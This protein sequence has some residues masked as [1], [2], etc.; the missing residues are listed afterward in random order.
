MTLFNRVMG[1]FIR[2]ITFYL[3]FLS[4]ELILDFGFNLIALL[5]D[6]DF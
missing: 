3:T 1:P 4:I 2:A 6:K 5:K